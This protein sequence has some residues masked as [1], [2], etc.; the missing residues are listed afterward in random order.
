LHVNF[1]G[2]GRFAIAVG[3]DV[4]MGIRRNQ[5]RSERMY[6]YSEMLHL[7]NAKVFYTQTGMWVEAEAMQGALNE[8]FEMMEGAVVAFQNSHR[9]NEEDLLMIGQYAQKI[10][11][12]NPRLINNIIRELEF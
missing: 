12:K 8:T 9:A 6:L 7:M 10:V 11:N 2:I 4:S 1:V 5:L 3:T